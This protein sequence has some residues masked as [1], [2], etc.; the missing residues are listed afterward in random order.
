MNDVYHNIDD[1]NPPRKRK[2]SL[3]FD[4]MIA[5]IMTNKKFQ[6]TIYQMQE[7]EYFTCLYHTMLFFCSKR[8]QVKFYTLLYKEDSQQKRFTKYYY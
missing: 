2:I 8:S 5:D 4:D 1:Y 3:V 7:L 6:R